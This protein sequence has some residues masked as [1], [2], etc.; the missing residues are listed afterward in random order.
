MVFGRLCSDFLGPSSEFDGTG[1]VLL[2]DS[3]QA[4]VQRGIRSNV[5]LTNE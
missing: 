5:K 3:Y 2:T 4:N 1:L